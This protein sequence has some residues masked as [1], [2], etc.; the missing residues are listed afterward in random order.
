MGTCHGVHQPVVWWTPVVMEA[1]RLKKETFGA[2][3]SFGNPEAADR[4]TREIWAEVVV[5]C[6]KKHF[7][8]Y[9]GH[10][11]WVEEI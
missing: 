6:W 11:K 1:I 3:S 7:V 5:R 9:K 2:W 8:L 4:V 10:R